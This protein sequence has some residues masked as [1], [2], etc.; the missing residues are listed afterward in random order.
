MSQRVHAE[1]DGG[2]DGWLEIASPGGAPASFHYRAWGRDGPLLLLLHELGG[3]SWSWGRLAPR[4][5]AA[6]LRVLALDQRGAGLSEKVPGPYTLDLLAG[7]VAAVCDRLS[8]QRPVFIGGLAMGSVTGLHFASLHPARVAGL[9]L[10]SPAAEIDA[11]AQE[12]LRA[13]ADLVERAGMRATLRA[14]FDNAFPAAYRDPQT[15]AGY[16]GQF[17][18]N[19]PAAYAAMSRALADFEGYGR[20]DQVSAPT[21]LVPGRHDF[22]WPPEHGERLSKRLP[23]A[24]LH[25]AD[26]GHFPSLQSPDF[27]ETLLAGLLREVMR[28]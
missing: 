18:A 17:L 3:S 9:V 27:C 28:G 4:L 7:D 10:F 5:A 1:A 16:Q 21:L 8:P 25:I 11:R 20:L 12:Y 26:S 23:S 2:S 6:G 13:R 15:V 19:A 14:S 24:R 22:I